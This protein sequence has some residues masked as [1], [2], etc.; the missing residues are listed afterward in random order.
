[1]ERQAMTKQRSPWVRGNAGALGAALMAQGAT[2][3]RVYQRS[4]HDGHLSAFVAREP[5]GPGG[6]LQ[7][8]LSISH[9]TNHYPPRPGRYPTWDEI[10]HAR[11]E[12][13]PDDL[14]F[15]M[16][17]PLPDEYV[18]VHDTTFHLHEHPTGPE[19]P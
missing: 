4:V 18:A 1:M 2:Q 15:V 5:L 13:L 12:L 19:A 3:V 6:A 9:R 11:Y 14:T 10:A 16:F 7:W 17:L 8:H